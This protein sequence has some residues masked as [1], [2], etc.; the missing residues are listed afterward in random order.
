MTKLARSVLVHK[1]TE[2]DLGRYP[3]VLTEQASSITHIYWPSSDRRPLSIHFLKVLKIR[4]NTV[5]YYPIRNNAKITHTSVPSPP[6]PFRCFEVQFQK[7]YNAEN[8]N[9]K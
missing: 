7:F 2:K 3:A 4:K 1:H 6:D 9:K 5:V 8:L